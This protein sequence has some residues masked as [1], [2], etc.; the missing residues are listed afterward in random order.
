MQKFTISCLRSALFLT[1]YVVMGLSTPC[2][3]RRLTGT[4]KPW[5]YAA[6]GAVA[7]SM[8]FIE[9]PGR[10]LGK[11]TMSVKR[12]VERRRLTC[13]HVNRTWIVLSSKSIR[14]FMED[15]AQERTSQ[16]YT[17]WRY[18]SVHGFYG[19]IDDIIPKRQ[20][21]NQLSLFEC[22]DTIFWTKLINHNN[23]VLLSIELIQRG[24]TTLQRLHCGF[25]GWGASCRRLEWGLLLSNTCDLPIKK[26]HRFMSLSITQIC[27][28]AL[29][30]L[31]YCCIL[32]FIRH[33]V[34]LSY[35]QKF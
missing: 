6:T 1:M 11:C 17:P 30:F 12:T 28:E 27:F 35:T 13:H 2:W 26:R 15:L 23:Y 16:E 29:L 10:Q 31:C 7:G 9:A 25:E 33:S 34:P 8:V 32:C 24:C 20:G 14:V 4:D 3:L 19:Y 22:H 18:S 5:I 21:Y